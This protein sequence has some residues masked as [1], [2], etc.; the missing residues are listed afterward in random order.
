MN[1]IEPA[2]IDELISELFNNLSGNDTGFV[3]KPSV[4]EDGTLCDIQFKEEDCPVMLLITYPRNDAY[5]FNLAK[6]IVEKYGA[7]M[8]SF[9]GEDGSRCEV[10][11]Y[12]QNNVVEC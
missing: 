11:I 7:K 12:F 5:V 8:I 1:N 9:G 2:I 4:G 6:P 3:L 10:L